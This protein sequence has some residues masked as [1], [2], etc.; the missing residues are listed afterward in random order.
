MSLYFNQE[1]DNLERGYDDVIDDVP[2]NVTP[3]RSN[4]SCGVFVSEPSFLRD[5]KQ[6][7]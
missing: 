4:V 5:A 2:E 1:D 3:T 7:S 6:L